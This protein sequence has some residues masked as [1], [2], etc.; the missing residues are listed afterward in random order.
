MRIPARSTAAAVLFEG[1]PGARERLRR[2]HVGSTRRSLRLR[3]QIDSRDRV[4]SG[5]AVF[6]C[7][8][9]TAN[10]NRP[11]RR[12]FAH[13]RPF[14]RAP[15]YREATSRPSITNCSR[16]SRAR[17]TSCFIALHLEL[18]IVMR[19]TGFRMTT[20]PRSIR[21][22]VARIGALLPSKRTSPPEPELIT[23]SRGWI[24]LFRGC[25]RQPLRHRPSNA[26]A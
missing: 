1:T 4:W 23:G 3:F 17:I 10:S 22:T 21:S 14:R 24:A 20:V 9:G 18:S 7:S 26:P 2:N 19:P 16:P 5:E 6:P 13:R 15:R 25:L 11:P 8:T 12:T